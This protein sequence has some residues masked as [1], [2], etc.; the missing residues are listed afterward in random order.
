MPGICEGW[1]GEDRI[2]GGSCEGCDGE[3]WCE[4]DREKEECEGEER[5]PDSCEGCEGEPRMAPGPTCEGWEGEARGGW[6][7]GWG[8]PPC[9]DWPGG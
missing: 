7:C 2:V 3:L 8:W 1:E 5:I 4:G 6:N 9:G